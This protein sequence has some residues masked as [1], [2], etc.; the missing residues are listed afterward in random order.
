MKK[1]REIPSPVE[2][3]L[4]LRYMELV[5]DINVLNIKLLVIRLLLLSY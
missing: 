1:E 4:S 5:N 2:T 3:S